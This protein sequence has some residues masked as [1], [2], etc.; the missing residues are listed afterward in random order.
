MDQVLNRKTIKATLLTTAGTAVA[1]CLLAACGSS[2]SS[3]SSSE[4]TP[5]GAS[6]QVIADQKSLMSAAGVGYKSPPTSG[7][8]PET[9]KNIWVLS[10]SQS[11]PSCS[12]P[13][14]KTVE[15]AQA[16]GWKTTLYDTKL[17]PARI[18]E[19]Y[20]QAIAS[21]AN[22]IAEYS[23]D[24]SIS[25]AGLLAAKQ[26]HI[27]VVAAEAFEDCG[28]P[29]LFSAVVEYTQGPFGVWWTKYGA[30]QATNVIVGTGAK[31]QVVT[32]TQGDF[33]MLKPTLAGFKAELKRSCSGCS[34]VQDLAW[35]TPDI[36]EKLQTK[37][38]DSLV[39]NPTA[40]SI[41]VAYDFLA[42]GPEAAI[43]T[44]GRSKGLFVATAEGQASTMD[45]LRN[46]TIHGAGVGIPQGWEAY[47][48]IDTL[49]RVM[50]GQKQA[51]SGMGIQGYEKG[52]NIPST[53]RWEPPIDYRAVYLKTWG[54]K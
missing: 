15:A 14:S 51:P 2:G 21:G 48:T 36:G 35:T 12:Y 19:G 38:Q 40:N 10:C 47:Q 45:W 33:P 1:V 32:I 37:V 8:K 13:A 25:K 52:H 20:R 29:N 39:R 30:A 50:Q 23:M 11:I 34:V 9:G 54:V 4:S 31:A 53:G 26:A 28:G 3:S 44:S 42:L 49:N 22:G 18:A 6:A 41:Y 7:P 5:S 43:R 27:P 16:L 46:G 17:D 24:C